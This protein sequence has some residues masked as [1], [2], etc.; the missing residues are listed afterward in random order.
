MPIGSNKL[1]AT[2]ELLQ[3]SLSQEGKLDNGVARNVIEK[4]EQDGFDLRQ[5]EM[6]ASEVN[7]APELWTAEA[8]D[9]LRYFFEIVDSAPKQSKWQYGNSQAAYNS[10]VLWTHDPKAAP[11]V[12]VKHMGSYMPTHGKQANVYFDATRSRYEHIPQSVRNASKTQ[13]TNF[14]GFFNSMQVYLDGLSGDPKKAVD[15]FATS[16]PNVWKKISSDNRF[17]LITQALHAVELRNGKFVPQLIFT[18]ALHSLC[19]KEGYVSKETASIDDDKAH[20]PGKTHVIFGGM[21]VPVGFSSTVTT[22]P[23]IRPITK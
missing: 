10:G 14:A 17:D 20:L 9:N 12:T 18:A 7:Q 2:N 1:V 13:S 4:L 19:M 15:E 6:I 23:V 16:Y 5:V 22:S 3:A 11:V 21:E 8:L